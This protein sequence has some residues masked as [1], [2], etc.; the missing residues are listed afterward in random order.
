MIRNRQF[1]LVARPSGMPTA[2]DFELRDAAAPVLQDGEFLIRNRF[3]SLDPAMRN[4]LD[5]VETY[6][7]PVRIGDPMRA[8]TVGEVEESQ[9]E[10]MPKGSWVKGVNAIETYSIGRTGDSN[11]RIDP[12]I[13]GSMSQYIS[14]AGGASMTA[15]FGVN[16]I[17]KPEPGQTM[18]VSSAA[19]AVGAVACQLGKLAGARVIGIAGGAQK[20]QRLFGEV[21]VDQAIDRNGLSE[22]ELAAAIRAAAPRGVDLVFENVGGLVLDA[23][24]RNLAKHA[25]IA[26]CGLISEYNGP[27]LGARNLMEI[28]FA[29]ATM[30]G[31]VMLDFADEVELATRALFDHAAAGRIRFAEH[32]VDGIDQALPA[33]LMLFEGGNQGKLILK[34]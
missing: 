2:K 19:G 5:D 20:C 24:L 32:V 25:R 29:S 33:F 14:V 4:W 28:V 22:D 21:G 7:P 23:T 15:Y 9:A 18:L 10:H 16:R 13:N 8:G 12:A 34:L 26:L 30:R 27:R 31:F 11:R 17:L 6:Y 3:A 1:V